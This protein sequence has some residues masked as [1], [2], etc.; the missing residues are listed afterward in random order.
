MLLN[1]GNGTFEAKGDYR[2]RLSSPLGR[3]GD[4]NGDGKLDLAVANGV[5]T[6]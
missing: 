1:S 5:R 2:H 3:V 6:A 4:L